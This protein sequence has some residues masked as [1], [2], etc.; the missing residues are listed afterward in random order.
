MITKAIL[1]QTPGAGSFR[2]MLGARRWML[3]RMMR[4]S[5]LVEYARRVPKNLIAAL[6]TARRRLPPPRQTCVQELSIRR[7][8]TPDGDRRHCA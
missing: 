7:L 5:R 2:R 1:P 8:R 3:V 6:E 4:M